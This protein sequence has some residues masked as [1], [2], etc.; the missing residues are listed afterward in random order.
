M[1]A[2]ATGTCSWSRVRSNSVF[3]VSG[4]AERAIMAK[5]LTSIASMRGMRLC[6]I[7]GK[8]LDE[9]RFRSHE[10]AY[11]HSVPLELFSPHTKT[12]PEIF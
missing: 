8:P 9:T 12:T 2:A 1:R 5:I 11:P 10:L 7:Q 6:C 4:L 3:T